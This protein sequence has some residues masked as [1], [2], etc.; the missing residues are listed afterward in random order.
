MLMMANGVGALVGSLPIESVGG[1]RHAGIVRLILGI[2]FGVSLAIFSCIGN[3]NAA[4]AAL[5]FLGGV[6]AAY[7][8]LNA[9]LIMEKSE[10][11]YHGRVMS[12]YM[13]I[14]SALPPGNM[15]VS[16]LDDAIGAPATIGMGG[17]LLVVI[18]AFF[19]IFSGEYRGI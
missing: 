4:M 18:V 17:T 1:L 7:L 2:L 12:I 3:H 19:G 14:S 8:A 16:L 6:S 15:L 9:T 10:R 5:L 13:P 11:Q